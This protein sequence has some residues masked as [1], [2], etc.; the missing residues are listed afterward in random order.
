M[1]HLPFETLGIAL[2]ALLF[3]CDGGG[4]DDDTGRDTGPGGAQRADELAHETLALD[5]SHPGDHGQP[6]VEVQVERVV[7]GFDH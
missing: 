6:I 4:D 3:A 5:P 2:V 7:T 1:S